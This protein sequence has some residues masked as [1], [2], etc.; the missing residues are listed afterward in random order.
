MCSSV[1]D[2]WFL[3]YFRRVELPESSKEEKIDKWKY[4]HHCIE[5]HG[6][7]FKKFLHFHALWQHLP[8]SNMY[9]KLLQMFDHLAYLPL[10]VKG[11]LQAG[12]CINS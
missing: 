4:W 9:R 7:L 6:M 11:G 10:I 8:H 1:L 3:D 5:D 2:R 12:I